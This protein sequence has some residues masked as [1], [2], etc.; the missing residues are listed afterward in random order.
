[1]EYDTRQKKEVIDMLRASGGGLGAR[2]L[3]SKL[4]DVGLSSVY[5]IL[6]QACR[7]GLVAVSMRGRERIWSYVGSCSHH[8][9]GCCSSCGA[10]VHIDEAVSGRIAALLEAEGL[11]LSEGAMI[12]LLCPECSRKEAGK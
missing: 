5:R 4:G 1:M 6:S 12:S 8:L 7:E 2:E 9:H 11:R 10:L 3:A